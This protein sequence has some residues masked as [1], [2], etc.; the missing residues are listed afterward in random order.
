MAI[1]RKPE[2]QCSG[3]RGSGG[4]SERGVGMHR[5][6]PLIPILSQTKPVF[7]SLARIRCSGNFKLPGRGL[8]VGCQRALPGRGV[9]PS[10]CLGFLRQL[11]P[12]RGARIGCFPDSDARKCVSGP[13]PGRGHSGSGTCLPSMLSQRANGKWRKE[14]LTLVSPTGGRSA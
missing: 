1:S 4:R 2:F 13:G 5:P 11:L 9:S 12:G 14:G 3:Y 8:D 7:V 10:A 6:Q